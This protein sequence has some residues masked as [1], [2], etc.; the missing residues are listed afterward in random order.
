MEQFLMTNIY[1]TLAGL[2]F[3]GL[4]LSVMTALILGA[5]LANLYY[6]TS[7][8]ATKGFAMTLAIFPPITCVVL[9][10]ISKNFGAGLAVAGIFTLVKFKS[11]A[12]NAK[13][14]VALFIS[15]GIGI[16]CGTGFLMLAII[17]SG[18][19][20]L[21]FLAYSKMNIWKTKKEY[22]YVRMLTIE[23]N[24]KTG[25]R[26]AIEAF[27]DSFVVAK[28]L[29]SAENKVAKNKVKADK[30]KTKKSKPGKIKSENALKYIYKITFLDDNSEKLLLE[31]LVK[32]NYCFE[33]GQVTAKKQEKL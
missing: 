20:L 22:R 23:V 12:G 1:G 29:V 25:G 18:S 33:F 3:S 4:L 31:A 13:E 24:K 27:L 21:I 17:F 15:T 19:I 7:T 9:L 26:E 16:L 8:T 5:A 11:M 30:E 14:M 2:S 6:A 32:E 10:L 28:S